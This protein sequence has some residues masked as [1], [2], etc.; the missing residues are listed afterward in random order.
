M[1]M[2]VRLVVLPV[3][4]VN[5]LRHRRRRIRQARTSVPI[6][7]TIFQHNFWFNIYLI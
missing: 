3:L 1:K 7:L 2:P 6:V 5:Q 4:A